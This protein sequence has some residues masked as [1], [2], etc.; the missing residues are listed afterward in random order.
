MFQPDSMKGGTRPAGSLPLPVASGKNAFDSYQN[1]DYLA[2]PPFLRGAARV[3]AA[4]RIDMSNVQRENGSSYCGR[5]NKYFSFH[6]TFSR[7]IFL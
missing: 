6:T 4:W 5:I 3:N 2:R 1:R 7:Y